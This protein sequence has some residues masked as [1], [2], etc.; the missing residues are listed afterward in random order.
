MKNLIN[1]NSAVAYLLL[2]GVGL[3]I[4]VTGICYSFVS[5]FTDYI[6]LAINGYS[7]T[8]LANQ[9][10]TDSITMG[11]MLLGVFKLSLVPSL[12]AIIYFAFTMS[13]K[14]QKNW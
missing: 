14:M 4:V 8:P 9:Q 6:L 7:G 10:D 11:N 1:D 2:I 12:I 3:T 5:D 13:Q